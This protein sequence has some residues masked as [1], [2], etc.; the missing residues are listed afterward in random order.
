MVETAWYIRDKVLESL[1][2]GTED[3]V[4]FQREVEQ[5][6]Y[7]DGEFSE[8]AEGGAGMI[9]SFDAGSVVPPP[10]AGGGRGLGERMR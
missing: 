1:E 7:Q 5:S 8:G 4:E 9:G 3:G 2:K 10:G 6:K